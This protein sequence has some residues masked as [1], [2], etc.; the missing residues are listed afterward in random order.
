MVGEKEGQHHHHQQQ[1]QQQ[2][3]GVGGTLRAFV[4]L[5][6]VAQNANPTPE[7]PFLLSPEKDRRGEFAA[8]GVDD[9][10]DGYKSSAEQTPRHGRTGGGDGGDDD[11]HSSI[12]SQSRSF[13]A[14][15]ESTRSAD[16]GDDSMKEGIKKKSVIGNGMDGKKRWTSDMEATDPIRD[17]DEDDIS[18]EVTRNGNI[19]AVRGDF[20]SI[21]SKMTSPVGGR[22]SQREAMSRP[23]LW[24]SDGGV[25]DLS[26]SREEVGGGCPCADHHPLPM[27]NS[28]CF[29]RTSGQDEEE[30]EE[31]KEEEE[32][33]QPVVKKRNK[34]CAFRSFRNCDKNEGGGRG[35]VRRWRTMNSR[36]T[37]ASGLLGAGGSGAT[38]VKV[39]RRMDSSTGGMGSIGGHHLTILEGGV[40][41]KESCSHREE[42]FYEMLKPVQDYVWRHPELLETFYPLS[43]SSSSSSEC[44]NDAMENSDEQQRGNGKKGEEGKKL[45]RQHS[46]STQWNWWRRRRRLSEVTRG[47]PD[48]HSESTPSPE[49]G[50]SRERD[51]VTAVSEGRHWDVLIPLVPFVPR[52]IGLRRV[53]LETDGVSTKK[54]EWVPSSAGAQDGTPMQRCSST[55]ATSRAFEKEGKTEEGN[56]CQMIVLEDLC[57]GFLHP[58]ILDIKMG[59]RQYGMNPSEAKLRSKER[60]AMLSTSMQYGVRLAGMKR[61][62]PDTQQY[63]TR[64][65]VAGRNLTLEELRETISRFTQCSKRLRYKFRKQVRRL[66]CAFMNQNVF[67]FFTSSL[68]FVY[69]A[70]RPLLSSR[71][72]MVDFAFTYER[73]ELQRGGDPEATYERDFGYIKALDTMLTILA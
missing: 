53:L 64:S 18:T 30:D 37:T 8:A 70:D 48:M 20:Q 47:T 51:T 42:R 10:D 68:L 6:P 55:L 58:C 32:E 24:H 44:S 63:E 16:D 33:E 41:M 46:A 12:C 66:R 73:E 34:K 45:D 43:S 14:L 7:S 59:S 56:F 22:T 39:D 25:K 67:R 54:S 27:Y 15:K 65:K 9:D 13:G 50:S 61:W 11:S 31:K 4:P 23:D 52:Y 2:E 17:D 69:D 40:F 71:V 62:C 21:K 26:S 5:I 29:L 1:Q 38:T 49:G 57:K 28:D 72:V 19:H 3:E 60:K 35:E 36:P